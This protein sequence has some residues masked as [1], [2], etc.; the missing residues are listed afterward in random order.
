[1]RLCVSVM[2]VTLAA[3]SASSCAS[4]NQKAMSSPTPAAGAA[5]PSTEN[6]DQAI[7]QL[8]K[9]RDEAIQKADTAAIDRIY[10]DDYMSTNSTA[11]V[12]TKAQVLDDLKSGAL[13][14]ESITSDDINVR[15]F[16]DTAIVTGRTTM[17]AQDRGQQTSG[18]SRFTQVYVKRNGRWQIVAFQ[19]T[20]IPQQ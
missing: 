17:K 20:R 18:Q 15:P 6:I 14:V 1:M 12:R 3:V 4:D 10:A 19:M 5:T 8:M 11:L 2:I 16:G 7:R 13:K 9:E